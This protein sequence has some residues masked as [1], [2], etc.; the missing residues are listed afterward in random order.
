MAGINYR[1]NSTVTIDKDQWVKL[2]HYLGIGAILN[3]ESKQPTEKS[4]MSNSKTIK[5]ELK[6]SFPSAKFSVKTDNGG[7]DKCFIIKYIDGPSYTSVQEVTEKYSQVRYDQHNGEILAGCNVFIWIDR[8]VSPELMNQCVEMM[9]A[10]GNQ[11]NPN[12][13]CSCERYHYNKNLEAAMIAICD[14]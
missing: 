6:K 10:Q 7:H 3:E 12:H 8:T 2:A 4:I 1:L 14:G 5:A 13:P 9:K 11:T